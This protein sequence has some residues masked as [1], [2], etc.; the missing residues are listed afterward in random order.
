MI[1]IKQWSNYLII[2]NYLSKIFLLT[3]FLITKQKKKEY[4]SFV[5]LLVSFF[6]MLNNKC[7][8]IIDWL[9]ENRIEN[10]ESMTSCPWRVHP[11]VSLI[12]SRRLRNFSISQ[13]NK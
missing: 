4:L 5:C 6:I 12:L 1:F 10:I 8:D 11:G 13:A 3:N 7:D 2:T 9:I